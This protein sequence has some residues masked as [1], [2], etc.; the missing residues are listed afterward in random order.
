MDKNETLHS[1]IKVVDEFYKDTALMLETLKSALINE[2]NYEDK[3]V[4][5]VW[6]EGSGMLQYPVYWSP[7]YLSLW[8]QNKE[9]DSIYISITITLK[10]YWNN[11]IPKKEFIIYG[12]KF[13]DVVDSQNK[14]HCIGKDATE[15]PQGG[16]KRTN[17]AD[18]TEVESKEHFGSCRF[19]KRSL[20]DMKDRQAVADFAKQ[21]DSL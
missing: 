20:W 12:C 18:Y 15:N 1:A 2:Y 8:L 11:R 4:S 14:Y 3:S 17:M 16:F 21:V 9:D 7:A 6:W 19:I 13:K 5:R 10:E